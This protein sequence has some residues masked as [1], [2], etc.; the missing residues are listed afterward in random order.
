MAR[1]KPLFRILFPIYDRALLLDSQVTIIKQ[2]L[3]LQG[4]YLIYLFRA[5]MFYKK[6]IGNLALDSQGPS[7]LYLYYQWQNLLVLTSKDTQL[8]FHDIIIVPLLI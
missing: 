6:L 3:C 7:C 4:L 5:Q 8:Y 2:N 1:P